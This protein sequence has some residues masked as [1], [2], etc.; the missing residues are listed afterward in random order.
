MTQPLTASKSFSKARARKETALAGLRE[1]QLKKET[2]ELVLRSAVEAAQFRVARQIRGSFLNVPDRLAG[3]LAAETDQYRIHAI[4]TKEI[5]QVLE[6]LAGGPGAELSKQHR[7]QSADRDHAT[8]DE[9]GIE[10]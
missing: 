9:N 5:L 7:K 2:G 3:L 1:L 6:G 8:K 10:E 4:L